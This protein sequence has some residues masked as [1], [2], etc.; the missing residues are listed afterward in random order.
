MIDPDKI[1]ADGVR[2]LE[3]FSERLKDVP[4]TEE[5]HYV[6]DM[7]NVWRKDGDPSV[8]DGFKAG[9]ARL[10]PKFEDGYVVAEKGT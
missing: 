8:P 1:R 3:E 10:P 2:L 5:T 6:I 9:F 4:Q 7:T